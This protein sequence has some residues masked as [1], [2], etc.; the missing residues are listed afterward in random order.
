MLKN[1]K[2]MG[3]VTY[4]ELPSLPWDIAESNL[5]GVGSKVFSIGGADC[6]LPPN[7]ERFLTW[8]DRWGGNQGFGKRVLVL[9]LAHCLPL[10]PS[11][12]QPFYFILNKM[13]VNSEMC[14]YAGSFSE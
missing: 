5:V 12:N 4:Q 8:S 6:G 7:T 3:G 13:N 10:W 11:Q 1:D 2:T 9:D 14:S